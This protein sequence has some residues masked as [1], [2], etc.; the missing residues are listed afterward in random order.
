[1]ILDASTL[2]SKERLL[3]VNMRLPTM[4]AC[5]AVIIKPWTYRTKVDRRDD[6]T[7]PTSTIPGIAEEIKVAAS[8]MEKLLKSPNTF[9]AIHATG[10]ES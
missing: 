9:L 4:W 10:G 3:K 2:A 1:M 5:T 6:G 7:V 8:K